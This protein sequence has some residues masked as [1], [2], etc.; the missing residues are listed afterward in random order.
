MK[1]QIKIEART[2]LLPLKLVLFH[3]L[4]IFIV[5]DCHR[6]L[7]CQDITMLFKHEE[8]FMFGQQWH[9]EF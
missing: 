7:Y 3:I 4:Y 5:N 8:T 6:F 1:M 2:L 9:S